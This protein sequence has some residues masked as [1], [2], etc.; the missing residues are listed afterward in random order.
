MRPPWRIGGPLR[1]KAYFAA[2][3]LLALVIVLNLVVTRL[4]RGR[5]PRWAR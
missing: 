1:R 4:A 2:F 5:E 3:C